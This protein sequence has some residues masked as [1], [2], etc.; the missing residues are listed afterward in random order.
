MKVV[1]VTFN[2]S[3]R[4]Y[5][6]NTNLDMIVGGEYKIIADNT[7]DY[8]SNVRVKGYRDKQ[9][10]DGVLR[11]IT[12]ANCVNAPKLRD[13]MIKKVI[14]NEEKGTTVVI[15]TDGQKTKLKC[16]EGDKFDREKALAL[17]YMKRIFGNRGA[18]NDVIH[19]WIE[20]DSK[21]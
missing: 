3:G 14:F 17:C 18:F 2:G 20:E 7:I 5:E 10:Y 13:D 4:E 16:H 15:W 19:K 8:K 6:Y 11:E 9:V 1:V 21:A 12:K